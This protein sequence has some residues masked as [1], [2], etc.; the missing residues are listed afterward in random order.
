[1][2]CGGYNARV[3]INAPYM[4]NKS[5]VINKLH[6]AIVI[7]GIAI[8]QLLASSFFHFPGI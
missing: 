4:P 6:A 5:E 2:N 3:T 7:L 8:G 1:L